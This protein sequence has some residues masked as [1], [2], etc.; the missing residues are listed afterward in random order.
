M[1]GRFRNFQ[2]LSLLKYIVKVY[3]IL[4]ISKYWSILMKQKK[5]LHNCAAAFKQEIF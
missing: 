2:N 3:T 5:P 4:E 1:R